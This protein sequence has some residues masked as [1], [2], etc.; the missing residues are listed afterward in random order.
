[1]FSES[2]V[3]GMSKTS[4]HCNSIENNWE[5]SQLGGSYA[6]TNMHATPSNCSLWRL[7]LL[8]GR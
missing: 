8:T 6:A 3:V 5:R 7:I 2:E 4:E 1:M